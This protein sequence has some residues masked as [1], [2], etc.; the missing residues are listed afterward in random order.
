[1]F[2]R[3]IKF[4]G[5]VSIVLASLG[6]LAA[7]IMYLWAFSQRQKTVVLPTPSGSY[8]V[9]RTVFDW[10]DASRPEIFSKTPDIYRE[11]IVWIWYPAISSST[12]HHARYLPEAW[13]QALNREMGI[14]SVFYQRIDTIHVHSLSDAPLSSA[15]EHYPVLIL[16]AGYGRL[17]TDYTTLAEDVT[18]HGYI[19]AGVANTYSA[20]VVVFPDGRVIQRSSEASIPELAPDNGDAAAN[21]LVK[22]WAA[23]IITVMDQL[24]WLN[25]DRQSAFSGRLDLD[26]I[27]VIGHSF[28]GA[29]TAQACLVDTRCKAGVDI[30]GTLYGDVPQVGVHPPFLFITSE[31][32]DPS[33]QEPLV[34]SFSSSLKNGAHW[35]TILGSRHFS[36]TDLAVTFAPAIKIVGLLGNIDGHRGLQITSDYILAFFDEYL[37]QRN[38]SLLDGPSPDYPEVQFRTQ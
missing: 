24:K 8:A 18:S 32:P 26:R 9:G 16:S 29:A 2:R 23:D 27:G 14:W 33:I 28:G 7:I 19:V 1:M 20:P 17:P 36:F 5:K 10:V 37:N 34:R 4:I 13:E 30:D 6:L 11:L 22:V 3:F 15:Q 21:Q 25:A 35:I 31:P 38:N 12:L